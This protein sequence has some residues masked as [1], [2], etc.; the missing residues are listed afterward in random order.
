MLNA[1][2]CKCMG[3]EEVR[4]T[5]QLTGHAEHNFKFHMYEIPQDYAA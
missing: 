3:I 1:P 4:V 2:T 5:I